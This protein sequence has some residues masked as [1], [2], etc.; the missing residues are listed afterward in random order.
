[1]NFCV[2]IVTVIVSQSSGSFWFV[3]LWTWFYIDLIYNKIQYSMLQAVVK[4]ILA[5]TQS[6]ALFDTK[7]IHMC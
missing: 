5:Q 4:L 6:Y 3:L 2:H 7:N 1:M